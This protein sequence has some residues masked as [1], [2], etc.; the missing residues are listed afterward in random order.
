M[1]RAA[2]VAGAAATILCA[3]AAAAESPKTGSLNDIDHIIVFMQVRS[4]RLACRVP[5]VRA[6]VRALG[7]VRACLRTRVRARALA[8]VRACARACVPAFARGSA[9]VCSRCV[10]PPLQTRC[11]A[12]FLCVRALVSSSAA[13]VPVRPHAGKPRLRS[14]L[15]HNARGPRLQRP[16][17]AAARRQRRDAVLPAHDRLQIERQ[18]LPRLQVQ[19]R[20]PGPALL[21]RDLGRVVRDVGVLFRG[22][23]AE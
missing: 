16:R 6:C 17:C 9:C 19:R 8:C 23:A 22:V 2:A 4:L 21:P 1:P 5:C 15:R 18:W 12:S 10:P 7:C 20:E 3:G 13:A 11:C 14:L